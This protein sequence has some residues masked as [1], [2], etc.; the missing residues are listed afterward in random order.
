LSVVAPERWGP[1][2]GAQTK[3]LACPA[4]EV[5]Y[6]GAAG[7]G[8]SEC[9]L[10]AA[11]RQIHEP[12]YR[13]LLTRRTFAELEKNLIDRS[14][15][16]Y[17]ALG[18][19]YNEQ[20]HCWTFPTGAKVY[21]G[22]LEHKHSVYKYQGSEFQLFAPDELTHYEESQYLYL[23]SRLRSSKGLQVRVRAG[24]NPG[25]VGHDWVKRRWA[26]WIDRSPEYKGIRAKPGEILWYLPGEDG[27]E[28]ERWVPAGTPGSFSRC[29]V[30]ARIKDNPSVS[31][32]DPQ[33][34]NRLRALNRVDRARLLDGDWEADEESGGL[35]ER[36][37]FEV[38]RAAPRVADRCRYW[39]RAGTKSADADATAGVR[40][41]RTPGGIY[42]IEDIEYLR[43][44]PG[45]V[46]R[47]IVSCA[48]RDGDDCPQVLERDPG[49]AGLAEKRALSNALDGFDFFWAKPTGD[50]VTRAKPL[51]AQAEAGNVKLVKGDWNEPFLKEAKA[52]PGGKHDDMI[53]GASGAYNWLR[54]RALSTQWPQQRRN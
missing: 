42:Y 54:P 39:D 30:P 36:F 2:P 33:Y 16:Q 5:L 50:K 11:L 48:Q 47:A 34:E 13:A 24:T 41:A 7:G 26:P 49:S 25:G 19:R 17:P 37:W 52:F 1:W 46:E 23:L 22:H 3:F 51:S 27:P 18:G 4:Y 9:I 45:E 14:R 29:F 10:L 12:S 44:T 15:S 8:K 28:S 21:F 35:F 31:Q 32:N 6:G 38:V 40:I 43:G 20:K 53:D